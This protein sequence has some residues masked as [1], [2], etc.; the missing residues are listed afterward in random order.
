VAIYDTVNGMETRLGT[1]VMSG[2]SWS[3]TPATA[4]SAGSHSFVARVENPANGYQGTISNAYVASIQAIA[5]SSI[6]DDVG[7][8]KGNLVEAVDSASSVRYVRIDQGAS[9]VFDIAEVKIWAWINGV[10]T[11][12]AQG[13][14][15]SSAYDSASNGALSNLVD[16][17]STTDFF[18]AT[19]T[20]NNWLQIDLGGGY[21]IASVSVVTNSAG[22]NIS[23]LAN[24]AVRVS[25]SNMSAYTSSQ[26]ANNANVVSSLLATLSVGE[27]Q[28]SWVKSYR[29]DDSIPA[30]IGTLATELRANEVVGIWDG[31]VRLGNANVSNKT[32]SY[33]GATLVDGL[34]SFIAKVEN[35]S[36]QIVASTDAYSFIKDGTVPTQGVFISSVTDSYGPSTGD[37]VS[38]VLTDDQH[39]TL[40]GQVGVPTMTVNERVAIYDGSTRLGYATVNTSNWI[41]SISPNVLSY[42]DHSLTAVVENSAT[43]VAGI[44]SSVFSVDVQQIKV[45]SIND[46]FGALTGN[47][48]SSKLNYIDSTG[49]RY[50]DPSGVA[51]TDDVAAVLNGTLGHVL[52]A[53][54]VLAVYDGSIR[55]GNA[56]VSDTTW[57][58][59]ASNLTLGSHKLIFQIEN[60]AVPGVALLQTSGCDIS[61][62]SQNNDFLPASQLS[63]SGAGQ[64]LNLTQE[65]AVNWTNILKSIDLTGISGNTLQLKSTD[66]LQKAVVGGTEATGAYAN[67]YQLLINGDASSTIDLADGGG[68]SGWSIKGMQKTINSSV[69]DVW[70]NDVNHATLYINHAI[71]SVI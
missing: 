17:K 9:G 61:V 60:S 56:S 8:V 53:T 15:V 24:A 18:A 42:G 32:W 16:G 20:N 59:S 67:N 58:F 10:L 64:T 47:V 63:L 55:L 25:N 5:M 62:V 39:L 38:G 7:A 49:V 46:S 2:T 54:Q 43:G 4:L 31:A 27:N 37:I 22:N 57:K 50:T 23:A 6:V 36:G 3:Y 68:T 12:V 34:H 65:K 51:V 21:N 13:K 30:L 45:T 69:Y 52:G 48:L 70:V 14:V 11:N 40:R 1:A 66:V 35:A 19:S 71:T 28:L 26:L 33:S 41:Y 29:S 44:A